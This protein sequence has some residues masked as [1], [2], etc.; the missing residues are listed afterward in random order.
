MADEIKK[1]TEAV[2]D[3]SQALLDN[4]TSGDALKNHLKE[5]FPLYDLVKDKV[6]GVMD[7]F[8]KLNN[9]V[10]NTSDVISK[11]K[12][13]TSAAFSKQDSDQVLAYSIAL[14]HLDSSF[15]KLELESR[16][17]V[18]QIKNIKDMDAVYSVADSM[19]VR[20]SNIFSQGIVKAKEYLLSLAE[21]ADAQT[22]I[23]ES[24]FSMGAIS[25]SID[26]IYSKSKGD[27]SSLQ[28]I[29]SLVDAQ[30]LLLAKSAAANNLTAAEIGKYYAQLGKIPGAL[31]SVVETSTDGIGTTDMLTASI[32][33]AASTGRQY[34]D[35]MQ[36]LSNAYKSYGLTGEGALQFSTRMIDV[37][38]KLNIDVK[39]IQ[40]SLTAAANTF[41]MYTTSGNGALNM[42]EDLARVM[43]NFGQSLQSTGL[44]AESSVK[45]VN[46][47]VGAIGNLSTAQKS[48]LSS[49][50][51]G[52][53]GLMGA[54]QIE[55]DLQ[56]GNFEKV[57]EKVKQ[58]MKSQLGNIVSI[59]DAVK[60]EGAAAQMQK[61]IQIL[62][63]GPL[64]KFASSSAEAIKILG[65]FSSAGGIKELMSKE[66]LLPSFIGRGS[67]MQDLTQTKLNRDANA[68]TELQFA[69][70]RAISNN[71]MT[72]G[73]TTGRGDGGI[74]N[75]DQKI[76]R[77]INTNNAEFGSQIVRSIEKGLQPIKDI[78]DASGTDA[79]KNV[80]KSYVSAQGSTI[81][82]GFSMAAVQSEPNV[83]N[84]DEFTKGNINSKR[85]SSNI[86][87]QG[88]Q[89]VLKDNELTI[90][91]NVDHVCPTCKEKHRLQTAAIEAY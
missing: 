43:G 22:R 69:Q 2:K 21:A 63:D 71:I 84:T 34:A 3:Y 46:N 44:S 9:M 57:F 38:S 79:I 76:M 45:L 70:S 41:S 59:D 81:G 73:V 87:R 17:F 64:G 19:G 74:L 53:G 75:D 7:S 11:L 28:M 4:I 61:Q 25:G 88:D 65:A 37:S 5:T 68:I 85:G 10:S 49:Q 86:T 80:A 60:S 67:D 6:S 8:G 83:E 12:D 31:S 13:S 62:Q 48:F 27:E 66:E 18:E 35:I 39:E 54:F 36:D 16:S 91:L 33:L 15:L 82:L 50:T 47:M 55:K 78:L 52:P 90:H 72:S 77:L 51:G 29:N 26:D 89:A 1:A 42:S 24:M 23:R 40:S 14:T 20:G 58:Q 32:K 56:D 30:S